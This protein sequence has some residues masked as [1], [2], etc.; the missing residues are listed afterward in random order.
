[1][2]R[3]YERRYF[4]KR[5]AAPRSYSSAERPKANGGSAV[6]DLLYF[7]QAVQHNKWIVLSALLLGLSAA[8]AYSL[9]REPTY[10][11]YSVVLVNA[12]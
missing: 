10:E 5:K 3:Y 7:L 2:E 11:S 1:M 6:G 9:L 4:I 8:L 12:E